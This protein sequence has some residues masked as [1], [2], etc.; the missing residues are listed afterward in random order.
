V[1][2]FGSCSTYHCKIPSCG[3]FSR[4]ERSAF[5]QIFASWIVD[6]V[7]AFVLLFLFLSCLSGVLVLAQQRCQA[8]YLRYKNWAQIIKDP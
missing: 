7:V 5:L 4:S 8:L 6:L 1:K 3:G 2:S